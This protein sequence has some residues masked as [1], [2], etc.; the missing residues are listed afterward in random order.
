LNVYWYLLLNSVAEPEPQRD[1]APASDATG[2]NLM[3]NKGSL[4]KMS[5]T[6]RFPFDFILISIKKK[7]GEKFPSSHQCCG[8]GAVTRCGSGSGSD[9]SGSDNGIKHC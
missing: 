8:A 9:G 7:S 3:F 5:Q 4:S 1:A 2:P 6:I